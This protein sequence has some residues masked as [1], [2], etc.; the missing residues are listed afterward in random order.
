MIST[1]RPITKA[2]S[3]NLQPRAVAT[4]RRLLE[5]TLQVLYDRGYADTT[6]TAVC[7]QAQLSRGAQLHHFPSKAE[8]VR[9][10]IEYLAQQRG[11]EI[12]AAA[13][14]LPAG[15][16]RVAA[17]LGLLENAFTGRLYLIAL[18]VW[19]AART[20]PELRA[21]LLPLEQRI[22]RE[23]YLLTMEV[24]DADESDPAVRQAV[25]LT[26]D[27]MRGLGVAALLTDDRHRRQR[28]LKWHAGQLAPLLARSAATQ[29]AC[30]PLPKPASPDQPQLHQPS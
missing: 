6:T 21:A 30:P 15:G 4:R 29:Q 26:L 19:V 2:G 13:A 18:E 22:G 16:D 9:A 14:D 11:A 17:A 28:L 3:R 25:Q 5:A 27:V 12:R 8:L 10:S 20:D 23:L 1:D 24:L 7:D